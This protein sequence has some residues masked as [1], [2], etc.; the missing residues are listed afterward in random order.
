MSLFVITQ[1]TIIINFFNWGM[2]ENWKAVGCY[3]NIGRAL[4]DSLR[5]VGRY[6]NINKKFDACKETAIQNGMTVFGLD[7]KR[8]WSGQDAENTYDDYGSSGQCKSN[9][10]G[11]S[12]GY[13]GSDSVSVYK[14]NIN[15][16]FPSCKVV[17]SHQVETKP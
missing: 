17:A 14:K 11:K 7:D 5:S 10:D 3:Q 12:M 13:F 8:C 2:A 9:K 15:G 6:R 16:K 4:G 1:L